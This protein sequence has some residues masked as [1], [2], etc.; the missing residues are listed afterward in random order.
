LAESAYRW[1]APH[2]HHKVGGEKR[3][4][5]ETTPRED[6][7]KIKNYNYNFLLPAKKKLQNISYV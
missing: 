2:L 4:E 6:F 1:S 7:F 5:K 3:K